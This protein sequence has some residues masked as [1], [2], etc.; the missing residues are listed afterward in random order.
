METQNTNAEGAKKRTPR[1]RRDWLLP[2]SLIAALL[3]IAAVIMPVI[4]STRLIIDFRNFVG[5]LAESVAYGGDNGTM[6]LTVDGKEREMT[7]IRAEDLLIVLA[8]SGEGV[9]NRRLPNEEGIL[10]TFGDGSSIRLCPTTIRNSDRPNE[11]FTHV[12]Y[13][14]QNGKVYAYDTEQILFRTIQRIFGLIKYT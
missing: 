2:A 8:R 4:Q 9:P 1:A 7:N 5:D 11:Q 6:V 14:D 3:L 13:T 12:H 10:L